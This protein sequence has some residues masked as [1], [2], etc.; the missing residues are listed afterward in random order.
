MTKSLKTIW[1][2]GFL[3][4]DTL[5]APQVNDL[6]N[7]K[8]QNVVDRLQTMFTLNIKW[9]II[10]SFIMLLVMSLVGAPFLGLYICVLLTPL[11]VIAKKELK[12]SVNLDKGQSSYEYLMNFDSWLQSAIKVYSSFYAW[13][14][15]LL[16]VGMA[17]QAV[18]SQAGQKLITL[19]LEWLPTELLILELPYYLVAVLF[20]MTLFVAAMAKAFYRWD[21]NIVYGR[22]FKKLQELI[23]DMEELR[24]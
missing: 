4:T 15:P 24:A 8:S 13:F 1:K 21:L 16:F 11:I 10:G 7:R 18:V 6:Y 23:A 19:M 12:K 9:L 5:L 22:Q 17:T 20:V 14:Y 2:E 3:Q